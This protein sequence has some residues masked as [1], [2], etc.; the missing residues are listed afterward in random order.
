MDKLQQ[1]SFSAKEDKQQPSSSSG[2]SSQSSKVRTG[3]SSHEFI[4][5]RP[6]QPN[7]SSSLVDWDFARSAF[8]REMKLDD[9]K[10]GL[11]NGLSDFLLVQSARHLLYL[12]TVSDAR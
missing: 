10:Q 7:L 11:L 8:R 3:I 9:L 12:L 6:A 2:S 5:L 4:V 1:L